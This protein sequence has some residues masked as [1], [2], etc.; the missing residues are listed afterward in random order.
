MDVARIEAISPQQIDWRR[1]TAKDI[2]KYEQQGVDVP[3]QYLEW[4]REIKNSLDTDDDVTYE[5]ASTSPLSVSGS[6]SADISIPID[7]T[8]QNSESVVDTAN[9]ES[10][11]GENVEDKTVAQQKRE[12]LQNDGVSL[13]N[14][15]IVFTQYS[16]L[17][18][19]EVLAA[20]ALISG[21]EAQ[22]INEIESLENY[23]VELL[24]KAEATQKDLKNEVNSL[25]K[26]DNNTN[27]LGKINKL[28]SQLEQYGIV[29]QASI[30]AAIGDLN[31]FNSLINSQSTTIFN[32]MDYG[33][34]TVGIGNDL[35]TSIKGKEFLR[36]FDYIAGKL[37]VG[38]GE[39]AVTN[40]NSVADVQMKALASNSDNL[41]SASGYQNE[42]S[43]VTGVKASVLQN[44]YNTDSQTPNNTK[45]E[46]E[47]E[48][49][50]S[51]NDGTDETAKMS[52]NIDEILKRKI[53]KGENINPA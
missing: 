50:V 6:E 44:S 51:Q 41:S 43:N 36:I 25:N 17:S 28:Q 26:D 4:A 53:R 47:K 16:N 13:R 37:A 8:S 49:K 21:V 19:E 9:V 7:L 42:V 22:S 39:D 52:T 14:Q 31:Q 34:A 33:D 12:D 18:S 23:M 35:L 48:V 29:G 45:S 30:S 3:A 10:M 11:S 24:A 40:S 20:G 46:S 32:A 38:I 1:L 27:S 2:I 5:M 15:A